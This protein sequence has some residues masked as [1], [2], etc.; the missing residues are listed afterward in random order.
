MA[1]RRSASPGGGFKFRAKNFARGLN[2]L[3]A[4][5]K[6][7]DDELSAADNVLL[8]DEGA[9]IRRPGQELYGSS[10]GGTVTTMLAPFYKSD[11]TA[12]LAKIEDG[13]FKA[14]DPTTLAW[15]SVG[16][17]SFPSGGDASY[18]VTNDILYISNGYDPLTKYDG[19]TLTRFTAITTPTGLSLSRGAS[20]ISGTQQYSYKV[21]AVN[22]VGETLASS[23]QTIQVNKK[24]E[25]WN[26]N[27]QSINSN[28]AINLTWNAVTNATGYNI[29]GVISGS[30]T[31]LDHVDGQAVVNYSDYGIK[32]TSNV[33]GVPTGN[34]T[35][36]PKAK[37]IREFKSALVL[38]G[39]PS[40]PSRVY[41]SA[42]V[43]KPDSFNIADGGGFIDVSKNSDD[44]FVKGLSVYQNRAIIFKERSIWQLDFTESEIPSLS[45][46]NQG[47]GAISHQSIVPVENDLF[48]AGRKPGGGAAIYVL[49]NEPNY[50]NVLRTNEVS[51]RVRPEL[52]TLIAANF[53][54]ANAFYIDGRY[55][56]FYTDG[57]DTSNNAAVIYDRERLGFTKS[58]S[59]LKA[60]H[61]V[62]FY[63]Q[64]LDEKVLIV[65]AGDNEVT[66]ISTNFGLDKGM[67]ISW[68]I[69]TKEFDIDSPFIYKLFR[70]VRMRLRNVSGLVT[71]KIWLDSNIVA[72]STNISIGGASAQT[73]FRALKFRQGR[74]RR[75]AGGSVDPAGTVINRRLPLMRQGSSAIG[76]SIAYEISGSQ[77]ESKAALLDV[78]FEGQAKSE[79]YYQ[80]SEL[81][82]I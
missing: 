72:Y 20:L 35:E 67:P 12:K 27:P 41:F 52:Q 81:I 68:R 30:E 49:G 36:A 65:D 18:A 23:A 26:T 75:T 51:A 62:I 70:W 47:L 58:P 53:D 33:F 79:N 13:I 24:R 82:D 46:I 50:L 14:Q 61:S 54:R 37:Y 40:F 19:S 73:A 39:D 69:R 4:A 2:T 77:N 7:R 22:A 11:G 74:F 38:G 55:W 78:E 8:V 57:N 44:G 66:E 9:P 34:T 32:I 25:E 5:S 76:T 59:G 29:Y 3:I 45:N 1:S 17:S 43:D 16:G 63:E 15:S 64:D 28:Y 80:R 6:I 48:F 60:K 42:G 56:L 21:S 71:L 31:Y 10:S